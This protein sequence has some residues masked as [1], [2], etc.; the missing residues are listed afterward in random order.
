MAVLRVTVALRRLE[1]LSRIE[2]FSQQTSLHHLLC[3]PLVLA[4]FLQTPFA[5]LHD[6]F[7][8]GGGSEEGRWV[9]GCMG[10]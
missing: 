9:G 7:L 2:Q 8:G 5:V 6:K 1:L 4:Q 10:K 3:F